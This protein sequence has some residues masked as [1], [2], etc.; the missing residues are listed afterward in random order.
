[1]VNTNTSISYKYNINS[2]KI[3]T[4]SL[5]KPGLHYIT[6]LTLYQHQGSWNRNPKAEATNRLQKLVLIIKLRVLLCNWSTGIEGCWNS[7]LP[8]WNWDWSGP[9]LCCVVVLVFRE[10]EL[11]AQRSDCYRSWWCFGFSAVRGLCC[12][13]CCCLMSLLLLFPILCW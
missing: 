7:D 3:P 2:M 5:N 13:G 6:T 8:L 12:A 9:L 1:M 11:N 10:L 4:K